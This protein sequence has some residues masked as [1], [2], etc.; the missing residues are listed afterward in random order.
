MI[1]IDITAISNKTY[2]RINMF[3]NAYG[4]VRLNGGL[5]VAKNYLWL[6]SLLLDIQT[7]SSLSSSSSIIIVIIITFVLLMV[8]ELSL[9]Y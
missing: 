6:K 7:S 4:L 1:L 2:E 5:H 3:Y 8:I 9:V